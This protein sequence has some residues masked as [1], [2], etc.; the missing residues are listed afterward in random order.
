MKLF[1][2][3][4][5]L[6]FF[7]LASGCSQPANPALPENP[8]PAPGAIPAE[9][10]ESTGTTQP[11]IPVTL[12]P[13]S[14]ETPAGTYTT[15][16]PS[17]G[18]GP[19]TRFQDQFYSLEYP[20]SWQYNVTAI[21]IHQYIHSQVGCRVST[22]YNLDWQLRIFAPA[23]GNDLFYTTVVDSDRD[24]W[25]RDQHGQVDY[26]DIVNE[27]LG[28]P[29]YCANTPAGAFTI[30]GVNTVPLKGVS[31]EGIRVDFGKIDPLGV[32]L[33]KGSMYVVT[34]NHRH[35]VF[36]YYSA[37]GESDAWKPAADHIFNSLQLDQNF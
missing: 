20:G 29:T 5:V 30:S 31:F 8:A 15:I 10:T 18:S 9:T 17:Q 1:A 35:G 21:P 7:I 36:T 25:P 13:A 27:I 6:L 4:C 37:H 2:A 28:D 33:G 24:I 32:T 34:G 3:V 16:P 22:Q 26:A 23:Q 11:T 12:P 14:L 19:W